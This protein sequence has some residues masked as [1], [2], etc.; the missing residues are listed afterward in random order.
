M[1]GTSSRILYLDYLRAALILLIVVEHA[2]L[3]YTSTPWFN[4]FDCKSSG[5]FLIDL[6]AQ[7]N[8]LLY[9]KSFR[10]SFAI[11]LLF[12]ISGLFFHRSINK[13]GGIRICQI[14]IVSYRLATPFYSFGSGPLDALFVL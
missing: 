2:S 5:W 9:I 6:N 7:N 4:F 1:N 11:S 8:S 13:R 10:L 14:Q 3:A 12:L